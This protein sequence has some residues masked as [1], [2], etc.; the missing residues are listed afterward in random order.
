MNA[1]SNRPASIAITEVEWQQQVIQLA[2]TLGWQYLHVRRSIGKGKR[3]VTATNIV[4]WPDLLLWAPGRGLVAVELK[5]GGNKP[6]AEQVDV[7][8][9]L[10]AAGVRTMV[11]YPGDLDELARLLGARTVAA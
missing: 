5:V 9:S 2:L 7:L 6:T 8:A 10:S 11:A 4:G 3:W 1:P